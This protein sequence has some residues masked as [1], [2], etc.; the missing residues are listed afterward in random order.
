MFAE[1]PTGPK[2]PEGGGEA[3]PV[4]NL[5]APAKSSNVGLKQT[6]FVEKSDLDKSI[7][8]DGSVDEKQLL[9]VGDSVY[10]SYPK[11]NPPKVGLSFG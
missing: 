10:L 7:M 2:E 11:D 9:A 8:I 4:D 5:P 1:Q 3:P 6:A